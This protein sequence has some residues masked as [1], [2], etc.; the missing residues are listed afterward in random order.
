MGTF[1]RLILDPKLWVN[2]MKTVVLENLETHGDLD[3]FKRT[4]CVS[5]TFP[6][7]PTDAGTFWSLKQS[8]S[9]IA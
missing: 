7:V 6:Y 5:S 8:I 1:L 3:T 4:V 9:K 2:S